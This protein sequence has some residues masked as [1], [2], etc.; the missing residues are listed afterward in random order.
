[1]WLCF[2][3]CS[4]TKSA[5]PFTWCNAPRPLDVLSNIQSQ[6]LD[7]QGSVQTDSCRRA[8]ITW[9]V[10][11]CVC[12]C[13]RSTCTWK[14]GS[15]HL[16]QCS[17][18]WPAAIEVTAWI[19]MTSFTH[20]KINITQVIQSLTVFQELV[21]LAFFDSRFSSSTKIRM[22]SAMHIEEDQDQDHSKA[23]FKDKNLEDF[24]TRS[25]WR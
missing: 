17:L 3:C 6:D 1:L 23:S 10:C 8:K 12:M 21:G 13:V 25:Q 14:P 2:R 16:R 9:C 18:Q 11:V 20:L 7:V 19:L 4:C 22:V 15:L 5:I 24:V